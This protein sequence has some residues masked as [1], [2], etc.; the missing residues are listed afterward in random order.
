MSEPSIFTRII[1]GE[2]PADIVYED[3]T[4][5]AFRDINPQA[6]IHIL[7]VPREPIVKVSDLTE[8]TEEIAAQ[9]LLAAGKIARQE[10]FVNDGYRLI[11]NEGEHG[12]QDVMHI[13]MHIMA[14][15][16]LGWPPG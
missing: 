10:G 11:L 7:V 8:G 2:I 16:K 15:R 12:G 5:V 3:D 9:L 6:P 4:V 14:G 1:S 13:H